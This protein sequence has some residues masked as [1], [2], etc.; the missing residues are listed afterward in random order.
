MK[1]FQIIFSFFLVTLLFSCG[2]QEAANE[3]AQADSIARVRT[4]DS[5]A[6][7]EAQK[8]EAAAATTPTVELDPT[9]PAISE[10]A[11][12]IFKELIG[13]AG[14]VETLNEAGPFTVFAPSDQ[15]L[16]AVK[17]SVKD[18][19]KL[20][21]AL[22]KHIVK[23]LYTV[24]D[25]IDGQELETISGEKLKVKIDGG[26]LTING[27]EFVTMDEMAKNGVVHGIN[28]VLN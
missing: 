16:S 14:L 9:K 18:A 3:K 24:P 12:G 26:V 15:T 23:G 20:K 6:Q 13:K 25:L 21:A 17:S 4:E 10:I 11:T 22:S 8:Q 27:A 2:N 5:L 19:E 1:I 7:L 28:K